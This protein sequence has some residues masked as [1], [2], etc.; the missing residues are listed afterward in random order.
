MAKRILPLLV[1]VAA[2]GGAY[3]YF[4]CDLVVL[5]DANGTIQGLTIARRGEAPAPLLPSRSSD[6]AAR[7]T[8]RVA[9]YNLGRLDEKKLRTPQVADVLVRL[10]P[11]FD[12]VAVQDVEARDQGGLLRLVE[13]INAT[14]QQY[15]FAV[16]PSVGHSGMERHSGFVFNQAAVEIDRSTVCSVEDPERRFRHKPLVALFRAKG[17]GQAEAF[18]FKLINVHV[19]PDRAAVELDL[20]DDVYR[21][22]RDDG[23]GED[24]VIMLGDFGV[25]GDRPGPLSQIPDV[26]AAIIDTPTSLRGGRPVDNILFDRRATREFTGRAEVFDLMR[27]FDL[28]LQDARAVSDHL[29]VWAEFSFYEGG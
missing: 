24:D 15:D 14:G 17:P 7:P 28:Q 23:T 11:K 16:C 3:V 22:V 6:P 18:T 12:V 19:E 10:L 26:T 25:A 29:P 2:V 13:Q 20:L 27:E 5:R 4:F 8:L 21:A 1:V 9:T